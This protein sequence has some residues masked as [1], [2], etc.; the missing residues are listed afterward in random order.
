[1]KDYFLYMMA[2]QTNQVLYTG[3]TND[4]ERRVSE[5]RVKAVPG[6]TKRYNVNKLVYFEV[7]GDIAAAIAREKQIKNWNRAKKDFLIN[8]MNPEWCDLAE[9]WYRDPSTTALRASARD[10][11]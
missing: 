5:H 4:L 9:N 3:V 6:F 10:D 2:N 8:K 11:S 1:M 7:F